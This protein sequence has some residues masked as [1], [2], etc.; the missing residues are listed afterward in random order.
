MVA[1]VHNGLCAN[2]GKTKYVFCC[3]CSGFLLV[4]Y[5][6]SF[7][8]HSVVLFCQLVPSAPYQLNDCY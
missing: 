4:S 2:D 8:C 7:F 5:L 1:G 6:T 3:C